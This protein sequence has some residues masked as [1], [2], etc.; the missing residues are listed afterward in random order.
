M[1]NLEWLTRRELIKLAVISMVLV[2]VMYIL[3]HL[4]INHLE[5]INYPD[6]TF[7][8]MLDI[9]DTGDIIITRWHTVDLGIRLFSKFCHIGI[10][11]RDPSGQLTIIELHPKETDDDTG[12]TKEGVEIYPLKERLEEFNCIS[13]FLKCRRPFKINVKNL[14]QYKKVTF[15]KQYR[16][17]FVKYWFLHQFRQ[18]AEP[19]YSSMYCSQLIGLILQ[20][21]KVLHKNYNIHT[22]SPASFECLYDNKGSKLYG[23]AY[24]II[25][26]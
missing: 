23:Q 19:D 5:M 11:N 26:I 2:T 21:S 12:I 1:G 15:D 20:D 8:N 9:A 24:R 18:K 25:D 10:I 4:Y 7:K 17:N 16:S 22:L 13:Y 3:A 6:I 14:E